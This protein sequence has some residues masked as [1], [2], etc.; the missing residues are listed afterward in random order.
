MKQVTIHTDGACEGNPGPGGWA[1]VLRYGDIAREI[2]GGEPA[3]TNNRMEMQAAIEALSRLKEPCEVE[4][5]TDSAYLKNGITEWVPTWKRFG[6]K[7]R[8]KKP[9]K[10]EDLWRKLDALVAGHA[11]RWKWVKGHNG[12]TD[13]ERCDVLACAAAAGIKK[14]YSR[15]QLAELKE[16]F[17][18]TRQPQQNQAGLL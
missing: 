3:T 17:E 11:V 9:I 5:F 1:A 16:Q 6:W 15:A 10:N 14:Q 2:S 8:G 12:N 18:A 7:I 4:I 13:N